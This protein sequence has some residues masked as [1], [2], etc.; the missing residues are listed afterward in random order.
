VHERL[1][2]YKR[3]ANCDSRDDLRREIFAEFGA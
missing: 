1:T 2:L 3:L